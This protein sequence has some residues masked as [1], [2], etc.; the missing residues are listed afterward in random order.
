[1]LQTEKNSRIRLEVMREHKKQRME[2]LKG[3]TARD[4][5]LCDILCTRPFCIDHESVPTLN[6]LE[7]YRT[8]L[9]DL[10][11]EKVLL[12]VLLFLATY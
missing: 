6:Q 10:T 3:F 8:Y 5:E 4:S 7:A 2:E 1:M 11:K 9:D 12:N